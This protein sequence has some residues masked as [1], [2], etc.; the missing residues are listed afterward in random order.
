MRTGRPP[1]NVAERFWEKVDIRSKNECWEWEGFKPKNGYGRFS[2][3]GKQFGSHR[4]S[5]ILYNEQDVPD[6][7]LVC[8][9]CDNPSCVNPYH[10]FLGTPL[11]NMRDKIYKGRDRY[12][13]AIGERNGR[14]KLTN[15]DVIDIRRKYSEGMS[16]ISLSK[17]YSIT[18]NHATRIVFGQRRQ[19]VQ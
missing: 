15:Q 9:K 6:G 10:L 14:H 19:N 2:Y 13:P 17:E 1:R 4:V 5:W 16:C 18:R 7:M 3:K 11:D 8:H 12:D